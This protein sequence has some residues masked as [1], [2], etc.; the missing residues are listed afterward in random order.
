MN[1]ISAAANF[2]DEAIVAF[3][4]N[5]SAIRLRPCLHLFPAFGAKLTSST[6]NGLVD[7]ARVVGSGS[8]NGQ[9]VDALAAVIDFRGGATEYR[10]SCEQENRANPH[11]ETLARAA[12][13]GQA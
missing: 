12:Q 6:R 11:I 13:G 7:M 4:E 10:K 9:L 2:A 5:G 3:G 8:G 1:G